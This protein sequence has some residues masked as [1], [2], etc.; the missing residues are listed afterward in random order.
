MHGGLAR[1]IS[2][3]ARPVPKSGNRGTRA[4]AW[5]RRGSGAAKRSWGAGRGASRSVIGA[6]VERRGKAEQGKT[7]RE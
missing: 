6:R 4:S 1:D 5:E 3:K 7:R 2:R